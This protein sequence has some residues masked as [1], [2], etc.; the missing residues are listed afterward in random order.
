[1]KPVV[2]LNFTG[3]LAW[4]LHPAETLRQQL[5]TRL[6]VLGV[7]AV[8]IWP[9]AEAS[10]PRP[11]VVFVD[12]DTGHDEQIPWPAGTAP[13]PLIGLVRSESPGRLTWALEQGV[14]AFL[15]QAALGLVYSTLVIGSAKCAERLRNA[16]REVEVARRAGQRHLLIRAAN[17]VMAREAVDELTALKRLRAFAMA[18]RVSLEDA[19]ALFLDEHELR[20]RRGGQR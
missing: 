12:V 6:A 7:E 2:D 14:D 15:P 5:A 4:V 3:R 1:M 16:R 11:D 20:G 18:R 13:V 10:A 9:V 19:A 17:Q 8:G